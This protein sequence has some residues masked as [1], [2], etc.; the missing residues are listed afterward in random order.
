M[1]PGAQFQTIGMSI[2]DAKLGWGCGADGEPVRRLAER[3]AAMANASKT[4][5]GIGYLG[6]PYRRPAHQ[7]APRCNRAARAAIP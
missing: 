7:S 4:E 6:S 2:N 3:S 1:K 5:R